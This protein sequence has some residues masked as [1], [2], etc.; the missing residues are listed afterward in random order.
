LGTGN[1]ANDVS[2][3]TNIIGAEF[4]LDILNTAG[5]I[6]L[7]RGAMA[8]VF[9]Y[10]ANAGATITQAESFRVSAAARVQ[11]ATG[12]TIDNCYTLFVEAA[13]LGV[14]SNW[15]LFVAGGNVEFAGG[16]TFTISGIMYGIGGGNGESLI[17][18]AGTSG[19]TELSLTGTSDGGSFVAS[20]GWAGGVYQF[21]NSANSAMLSTNAGGSV[22]VGHAAISTTATDGFLYIPTC[23]G[24]PTGTPTTETGLIPLVYDTTDNKLWVYNGSWQG[25]AV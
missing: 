15:S 9:L 4:E 13:T 18:K 14:D 19:T 20:L 23:A 17:L 10:G 25:V 1:A 8:G 7:A 16:G 2:G 12:G 3:L 21:K 24:A 5:T 22:L 11:G 6:A